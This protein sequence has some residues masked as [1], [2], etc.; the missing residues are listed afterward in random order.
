LSYC[1]S[2]R[3]GWLPHFM[4]DRKS[5]TAI[6]IPTIMRPMDSLFRI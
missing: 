3:G 5:P 2:E 4:C 6:L 1:F